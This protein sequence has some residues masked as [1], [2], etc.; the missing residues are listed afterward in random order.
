MLA[1]LLREP[2]AR[3]IGQPL[4]TLLKNWFDLIFWFDW[5]IIRYLWLRSM[6]ST[7]RVASKPGWLNFWQIN[8]NTSS[9]PQT[10]SLSGVQSM[11]DFLK[12]PSMAIGFFCS[13]SMIS[14]FILSH[15]SM[16]TIRQS[17]KAY[18]LHKKT[19][20]AFYLPESQGIISHGLPQLFSGANATCHPGIWKNG[21]LVALPS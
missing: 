15:G 1:C 2:L 20:C 3:E 21:E 10:A 5:M 14:R 18:Q 9:C 4:L 8:T 13:L 11:P 16:S 6:T 12:G 19:L 17:P 7:C